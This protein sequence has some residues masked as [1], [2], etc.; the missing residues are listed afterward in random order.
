M[1]H[2]AAYDASM[3]G[4]CFLRLAAVLSQA[5]VKTVDFAERMPELLNRIQIGTPTRPID[6]RQP[7]G[8]D[9]EAR[10]VVVG[11]CG[12]RESIDVELFIFDELVDFVSDNH[13]VQLHKVNKSNFYLQVK[14][15]QFGEEQLSDLVGRLNLKFEGR[16]T[17]AD[18]AHPLVE[19]TDRF[20]LSRLGY[21]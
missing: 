18:L 17:F 12:E 8:Q 19:S 3:T 13:T 7:D 6:L 10:R 20:W 1:Q 16:C 2:D 14:D 11:K 4:Y 9:E 5:D 15:E 21:V